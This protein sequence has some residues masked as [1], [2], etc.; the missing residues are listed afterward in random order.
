MKGDFNRLMEKNI[1]IRNEE[2]R[3]LNFDVKHI[4]ENKE[5][6]LKLEKKIKHLNKTL[7]WSIRKDI[8]KENEEK[9]KIDNN[10][11]QKKKRPYKSLSEEHKQKI[12]KALKG[13]YVGDKSSIYGRKHSEETKKKILASCQIQFFMKALGWENKTPYNF[14]DS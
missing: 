4:D 10:V 5:N 8:K 6:I 9:L 13:K 3:V 2:L 12:S 11:I 14:H 1:M 7:Q